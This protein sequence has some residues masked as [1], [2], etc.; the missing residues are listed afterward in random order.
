M[1]VVLFVRQLRGHFS[2]TRPSKDL[3][4]SIFILVNFTQ[5]YLVM[6]TIRCCYFPSA[7]CWKSPNVRVSSLMMRFF[8]S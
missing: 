7:L 6:T 3:S 8:M 5:G 1:L 2:K 4:S